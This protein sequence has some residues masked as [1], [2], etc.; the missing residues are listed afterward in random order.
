MNAVCW[1]REGKQWGPLHWADRGSPCCRSS[2]V[3]V[4]AGQA[5]GPGGGP[6]GAPVGV[7]AGASAEEWAG[8]WE[9]CTVTP[10]KNRKRLRNRM[11]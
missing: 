5:G 11:Y 3:D 8:T 9:Q 10:H 6:G 2:P 7:R 4:A 1:Q